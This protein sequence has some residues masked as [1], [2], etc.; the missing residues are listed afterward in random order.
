MMQNA[1]IGDPK[2]INE[3]AHSLPSYK[4][5]AKFD[6]PGEPEGGVLAHAFSDQENSFRKFLFELL[7]RLL[8]DKL[9]ESEAN[10]V[11]LDIGE[12]LRHIQYHIRDPRF[13]AYLQENGD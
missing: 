11:L 13:Y 12:E 8:T 4:C 5:V 7:A 9:S 3:L 6:K 10:D 2:Q 1:L